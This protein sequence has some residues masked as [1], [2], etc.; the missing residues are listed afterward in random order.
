MA[1]CGENVKETPSG[2]K[3]TVIEAGDGVVPETGQVLVF[4]Y[5]LKDS[6]DSVWGETFSSGIPAATLIDDAARIEDEDGMTQMFRQL[7]SGDSVRTKM[8]VT[9]FFDQ[10]V[11]APVPPDV[12]STLSI[13]YTIKVRNITTV[14]E[15]LSER[16]KEVLRRDTDQINRHLSESN[17]T[18]RQDT[19]GLQYIIR[20]TSGGKKPGLDNC[21]EVKYTGRFLKTGEIFDQ[22]ERIAFPLDG[23]IAGW[24]LGIPMLGVGDSGTFYIPSKLAYG[25]QG[26]PGAIP[27]DAVLVFDVTLLDVKNEFDQASRSCK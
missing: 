9:E 1:A 8:P 6:Q 5:E 11:G 19:S 26:Y 25:P 17:I 20:S 27:P 18:A 24:R 3:Y 22:A 4:H 21:V 15:F 14:E 23:V 13:S 16:E 12:D 7:S 2:L 10:I